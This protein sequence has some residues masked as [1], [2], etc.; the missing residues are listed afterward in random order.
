MANSISNLVLVYIELGKYAQ[1]EPLALRGLALREQQ[2]GPE[3]PSLTY[4]LANLVFLYTK[5]SVGEWQDG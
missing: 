1:A 3:H 2:L 4:S 5:D